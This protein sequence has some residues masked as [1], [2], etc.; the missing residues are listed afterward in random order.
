MSNIADFEYNLAPLSEGVI[1][2][3]LAIRQDFPAESVRQQLRQLTEDARV[4]IPA[5]LQPEQQLDLLLN[6]F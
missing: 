6:L 5:D 2:I 3:S 1:R 4:Q